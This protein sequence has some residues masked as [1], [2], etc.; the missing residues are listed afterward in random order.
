MIFALFV[1]WI[2]RFPGAPGTKLLK[3]IIPGASACNQPQSVVVKS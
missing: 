2:F 3:K 1:K